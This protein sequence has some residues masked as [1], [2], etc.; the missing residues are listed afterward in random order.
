M[1]ERKRI[2]KIEVF[3]KGTN[4]INIHFANRQALAKD[5][6]VFSKVKE[7]ITELFNSEVFMKSRFFKEAERPSDFT[8]QYLEL[9]DL[10]DRYYVV[11]NDNDAAVISTSEVPIRACVTL[12]L[13]K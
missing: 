10:D 6:E 13:E 1:A 4:G 7:S 5:G 3:Y 12:K 8:L 2:L 9:K 11:L